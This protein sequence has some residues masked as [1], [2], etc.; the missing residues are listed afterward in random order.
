ML[1]IIKDLL[2]LIDRFFPFFRFLAPTPP[3]EHRFHSFPAIRQ[4]SVAMASALGRGDAPTAWPDGC[5]EASLRPSSLLTMISHSL[6]S[7]FNLES[8]VSGLYHLS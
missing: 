5:K 1:V 2:G 3:V 8:S 4:P 7:I 6:S